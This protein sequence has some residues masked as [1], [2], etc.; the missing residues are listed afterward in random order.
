MHTLRGRKMGRGNLF[1]YEVSSETINRTT[2]YE[3]WHKWFK[4]LMV[5]IEKEKMRKKE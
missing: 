2:Q 3:E 1:W 4:P 5:Q